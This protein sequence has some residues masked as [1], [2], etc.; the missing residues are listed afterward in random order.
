MDAWRYVLVKQQQFNH[1]SLR[2]AA[3]LTYTLSLNECG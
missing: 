3:V 2:Y 1:C